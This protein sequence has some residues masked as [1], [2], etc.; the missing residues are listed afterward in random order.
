MPCDPEKEKRFDAMLDAW[1]SARSDDDE[2]DDD[3][4]DEK[5]DSDREELREGALSKKE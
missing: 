2:M 5:K 4:D 1:M 3:D